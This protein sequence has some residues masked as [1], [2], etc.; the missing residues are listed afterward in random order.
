[1]TR[2]EL[3]KLIGDVLKR[4]DVLGGSLLPTDPSQSEISRLRKKLDRMQLQLVKDDFDDSTAAFQA[5]TD[6]LAIV[7]E[8]LRKTINDIDRLVTIIETLKDFVN[9][10]NKIIGIVF[11]EPLGRSSG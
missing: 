5:A 10:V 2:L 6:K 9:V 8:S 1:M 7:N 4:L 11:P 3:I